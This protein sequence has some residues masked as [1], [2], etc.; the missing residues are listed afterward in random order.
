MST[1][2]KVETLLKNFKSFR[3]DD[4]LL[5]ANFWATECAEKGIQYS[6]FLHKFADGYFTSPESIR[7]MRQK[8]QEE[9]I[10]LRGSTY[11]KRQQMG[12]EFSI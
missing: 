2:T 8:L 5:M 3:D 10:E 1:K 12:K 4:L 11:G 9:N 6:D 7:R